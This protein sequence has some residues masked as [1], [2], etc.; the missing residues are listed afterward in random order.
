MFMSDPASL[1]KMF[2]IEQELISVK[3]QNVK[4]EVRH[5]LNLHSRIKPGDSI[6]ITAGSRGI[7]NIVD[8]IAAVVE[9]IK[10]C[11]GKPFIVPA[12]GSHGG[13]TPEGQVKLLANYGIAPEHVG[14]PIVSSLEV[15]VIGHL[16]DG[17]AVYMSR[18]A[19]TAD[20]IVVVNRVKPHTD[21]KDEIESGLAK[22]MVIGLGKQKGAETLHS[23]LADGYHKMLVKM[24]KIILEKTNIICGLAIVEN[25]YHETA[26]IKAIP[27][28]K[29]IEE[30]IELQKIAKKYLARIPFKEIDLLVIDEI[31][32]E[33]SGAGMDPN[34]TGRFYVPTEYE[35]QAPKVGKI[36]VLNLTPDS[37]GNATGLGAADLTTRRLFDKIDFEKT[38]VNT[39][40]SGWVEASKIPTFLSCDRDAILMG[41]RTAGV[42]DHKRAKIVLIKNTLELKRFLISEALKEEIEQTPELKKV[43]I[44]SEERDMVFDVLGNLAR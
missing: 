27:P 3:I 20:G 28:E 39:L 2:E 40:T 26:I 32:K 22:M 44:V 10:K 31:G 17:T 8:I 7:A 43:K 14:A 30:E 18:D 42:R 24:A 33:I 11:G 15:D 16:E 25:G 13:A 36:V 19:H 21:F 1:P 6:A 41:L 35:P 38:F 12:M 34:I 23:F 5:T 37:E 29:I 9:E 4:D